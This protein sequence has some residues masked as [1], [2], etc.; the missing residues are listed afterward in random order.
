VVKSVNSLQ[1]AEASKN[2]VLDTANCERQTALG[3]PVVVAAGAVD[4]VAS[5]AQQWSPA[6]RYAIISDSNVAPLYAARVQTSFTEAG[7]AADVL[8]ISSGEIHKTRETW[9]TVT[10]ELLTTGFRRDSVLVA[11]GGGVI[12]DLVGFVAATFMRGI[13]VIHVPTTLMAMVDAAIGGKTGVDTPAGKNLVGAF[14]WPAGVVVDPQVLATLPL[15]E[16][17]SGLAE[18]LKHG[19]IADKD[20]FGLVVDALPEL[21]SAEL[22]ND[23]RL[24]TFIA[25]SIEIK[26]SIVGGDPRETGLRK[27]LNFGHTIGHAVEAASDY[28]LLHGEAIAIGMLAESVAAERAGVTSEGTSQSLKRA[29]IAAGLPARHPSEITVERILQV[30]TTDKKMRRG[31]LEFAV[32]R[33]I[34]EMAGAESG[35]TVHLPDTLV[36]EALAC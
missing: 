2:G 18:V 21:L 14:H 24:P 23:E 28:S 25:R 19:A 5:Y 32:P 30:A 31:M 34:G 22:A 11:L 33:R 15:R 3:H 29:V 26:S 6:S 35:W 27:I 10:D 8:S 16:L 1:F 20:Y 17:Q 13:P 36:R 7:L 9:A 12:C 4:R